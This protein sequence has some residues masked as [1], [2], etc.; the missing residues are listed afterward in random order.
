MAANTLL[1]TLCRNCYMIFVTID[2]EMPCDER[3]N[4]KMAV[5]DTSNTSQAELPACEN[6]AAAAAGGC[7]GDQ[8]I[9]LCYAPVSAVAGGFELDTQGDC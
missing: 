8:T 2:I 6:L 4:E 9:G 5:V 1:L 3:S 7:C